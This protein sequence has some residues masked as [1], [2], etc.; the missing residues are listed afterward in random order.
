MS[1]FNM[2]AGGDGKTRPAERKPAPSP[3]K[4]K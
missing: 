1:K 2:A 4:K 3:A